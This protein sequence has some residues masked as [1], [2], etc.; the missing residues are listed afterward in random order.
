MQ[1]RWH[2][3]GPL[4]HPDSMQHLARFL[5]SCCSGGGDACPG[6]RCCC[7]AA[8]AGPRQRQLAAAAT[9]RVIFGQ[10]VQAALYS[11]QLPPPLIFWSDC[12][13]YSNFVFHALLPVSML[14]VFRSAAA[15]PPL[16]RGAAVLTLPIFAHVRIMLFIHI[17]KFS[18]IFIHLSS[19]CSTPK[20]PLILCL[21]EALARYCASAAAR[22]SRCRAA[23]MGLCLAQSLLRHSL[24]GQPGG[25]AAP[26]TCVI[27]P[28]VMCWCAAA[29]VPRAARLQTQHRT[30]LA[31]C[32]KKIP[33]C[34]N[35]DP[36][37]NP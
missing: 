24:R 12:L 4:L 5:T 36:W 32:R 28:L 11:S 14:C 17:P 31:C 22:F 7:G 18:S 9:T 23:Q 21:I 20:I 37:F 6:G 10:P 19:L 13:F 34:Y 33:A 26:I 29:A 27:V 2:R 30:L 35:V 25:R 16:C 15:A 8:D 3:T 1:L